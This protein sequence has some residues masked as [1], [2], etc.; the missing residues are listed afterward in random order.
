M[1]ARQGQPT[2]VAGSTRRQLCLDLEILKERIGQIVL[3]RVGSPDDGI[4]GGVDDVSVGVGGRRRQGAVE[5][6]DGPAGD[7]ARLDR[8]HVEW[9]DDLD[10][11]FD[12]GK[13]ERIEKDR[14]C[15]R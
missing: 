6:R 9:N 14:R 2:N 4:D 3:R 7:A 10:R 1:A 13:G 8:G 11:G 12:G 5:H 15:F